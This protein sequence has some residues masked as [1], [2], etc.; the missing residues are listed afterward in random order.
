[1]IAMLYLFLRGLQKFQTKRYFALFGA[2]YPE[3][4]YYEIYFFIKQNGEAKNIKVFVDDYL[5]VNENN[6]PIFAFLKGKDKYVLGRNLLI[7]KALA[8]MNGS[9]FNIRGKYRQF[10]ESYILTGYKLDEL[11]KKGKWP[12]DAFDF[13][14]DN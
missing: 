13:L 10:S 9:Y 2:C 5:L 7:E 1:M 12:D 4:G 3:I 14:L 8:K 6:I 11:V